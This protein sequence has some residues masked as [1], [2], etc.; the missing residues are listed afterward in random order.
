MRQHAEKLHHATRK[1]KAEVEPRIEHGS[2]TDRMQADEE[3][4]QLSY[5]VRAFK[6]N[7]APAQRRMTTGASPSVFNPG[8]IRG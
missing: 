3:L 2:N 6:G 4:V 5:S 1:G 7:G 8:F